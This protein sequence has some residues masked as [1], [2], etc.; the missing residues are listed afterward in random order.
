MRCE[1][2]TGCM[3]RDRHDHIGIDAQL[4]MWRCVNCGNRIDPEILKN[5]SA[6]STPL[7]ETRLTYQNQAVATAVTV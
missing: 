1:R 6:Q 2:C 4:P 7:P 3:M 5:R